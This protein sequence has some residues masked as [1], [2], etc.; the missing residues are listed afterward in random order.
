MTAT[1]TPTEPAYIRA[2]AKHAADHDT[3]AQIAQGDVNTLAGQEADA[4]RAMRALDQTR[5]DLVRQLTEVDQQRA[6]HA[7]LIDQ[8]RTAR[9][10]A[11][12]TLA[13]HQAE[14]DGGRTLIALWR[15]ANST[16]P[17]TARAAGEPVRCP[18]CQQPMHRPDAEPGTKWRHTGTGQYACQPGDPNSPFAESPDELAPTG[19]F[20]TVP[21]G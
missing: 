17:P 1:T 5:A 18:H 10:T 8:I 2:L 21:R 12:E 9:A 3:Q 4:D 11:D 19:A 6:D 7:T 15:Q 16:A 20:A 13:G 14:A